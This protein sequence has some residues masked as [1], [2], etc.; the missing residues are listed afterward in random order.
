MAAAFSV[1]LYDGGNIDAFVGLK[2]SQLNESILNYNKAVLDALKESADELSKATTAYEN[3]QLVTSLRQNS[4]RIHQAYQEKQLLGM[5]SQEQ[6]LH[7]LISDLN[8]QAQLSDARQQYIA[9]HVRLIQALGGPFATQTP[10]SPKA[11]SND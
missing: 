9:E 11:D 4:A 6:F 10:Q 5:V 3:L 8:S 2:H 1:P 7:S